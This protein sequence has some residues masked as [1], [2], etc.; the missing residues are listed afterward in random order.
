MSNV[1]V[2]GNISGLLELLDDA[3]EIGGALELLMDEDET[4]DS[5]DELTLDDTGIPVTT[6]LEVDAT[7]ELLLIDDGRTLDF[8]AALVVPTITSLLLTL[9]D[10]AIVTLVSTNIHIAAMMCFIRNVP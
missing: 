10:W 9:D 5:T 4:T 7:D 1:T 6:A 2:G 8:G 3:D